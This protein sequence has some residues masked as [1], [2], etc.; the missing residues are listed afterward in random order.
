MRFGHNVGALAL[1]V[2]SLF[3]QGGLASAYEMT[4]PTVTSG[5]YTDSIASMAQYFGI[6]EVRLGP[7]LSNLELVPS[8]YVV[9]DTSSFGKARFDAMEF[10]VYFKTPFPD[11]LR[12]IGSPRPSIG[13]DI[14]FGGYESMIHA[15]LDWHLPLGSTPFYLE[16]G[17]GVGLHTGYLDNAP[18]GFHNLG[19]PVL[20]HWKAG[21]GVN[22]TDNTT[23]TLDWSHMSNIVFKCTPNN[24]LND[25]GLTIGW[26]F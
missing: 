17:G 25:V 9:P 12:W 11:A 16:V 14:N 3:A 23:L 7:A 4:P 15:G 8:S 18:A 13:G 6:S 2:V 26:K 22:L 10:D 24:G 1:S 21:A 5:S 19:C 20:L